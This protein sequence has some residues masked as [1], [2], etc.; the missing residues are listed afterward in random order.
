M[1][2]FYECQLRATYV[3]SVGSLANS[4]FTSKRTNLSPFTKDFRGVE[5]LNESLT[6]FWNRF[7]GNG[8]HRKRNGGFSPKSACYFYSWIRTCKNHGSRRG[9]YTCRCVAV[10]CMSK[11]HT[12]WKHGGGE[13]ILRRLFIAG[14][15]ANAVPH[16][17]KLRRRVHPIWVNRRGQPNRSAMER[18]RP[19]GAA[20]VITAPPPPR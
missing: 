13:E 3:R 16:T 18:P 5:Q 10:V 9:R 17:Q 15:S 4:G 14:E 8:E 1:H 6:V 7:L 19:R 11:N 20:F 2:V 12:P